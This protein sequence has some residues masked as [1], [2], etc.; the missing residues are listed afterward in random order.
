[1]EFNREEAATTRKKHL[2]QMDRSSKG[3]P[4]KIETLQAKRDKVINA[5]ARRALDQV[6]AS[7][8][9]NVFDQWRIIARRQRIFYRNLSQVCVR[10]FYAE[11]FQK[12]KN[13]YRLNAK[14]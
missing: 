8:K 14:E 5:M 2:S 9:R 1:M 3:K 12:I 10:S 13:E 7:K 4:S 6:G 11:A